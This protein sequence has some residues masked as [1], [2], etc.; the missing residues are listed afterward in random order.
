MTSIW[1]VLGLGVFFLLLTWWGIL[2]VASKSFGSFQK[3]AMWA[4]VVLIPFIGC[5]IYLFVGRTK[6][7]K[8]S[9]LNCE[10]AETNNTAKIEDKS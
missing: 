6:G 5:L 7:I 9:N 2:D 1:I 4:F 8:K 3:K 10:C